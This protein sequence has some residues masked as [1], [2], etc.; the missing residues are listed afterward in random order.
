M[1]RIF[2]GLEAALVDFN[3]AFVL[4]SLADLV[5]KESGA[6]DTLVR[7]LIGNDFLVFSFV[8]HK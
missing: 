7:A 3:P 4:V 2:A 1:K 8:Y 5:S 6:I